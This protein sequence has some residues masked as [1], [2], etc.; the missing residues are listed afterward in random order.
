MLGPHWRELTPSVAVTAIPSGLWTM[1]HEYV[2]GPVKLRFEATGIWDVAPGVSCGPDGLRGEWPAE[3]LL[4][5]APRGA[6]VGMI[7]GSSAERPAG[8]LPVPSP[9]PT[10]GTAGGVVGAGTVFVVGSFCVLAVPETLR[11][12]LYLTMNDV[13]ED[14]DQHGGWVD[15]VLGVAR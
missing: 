15:V 10:G 11:G 9:A 12:A 4:A 14:F 7:G 8:S 3:S 13:V 1:V 6:L 2:E 5:T